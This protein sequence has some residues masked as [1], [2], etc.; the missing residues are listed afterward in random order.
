VVHRLEFIVPASLLVLAAIAA[1]QPQI[2]PGG[3][4]NSA[5]NAPVGWPNSSIA[6]GSIFAIYGSKLGPPSSPALQYPLLTTLVGVSVQIHSGG[7]MLNA[8]PI[9]AGPDQVPFCRS[10][11]RIVTVLRT[12]RTGSRRFP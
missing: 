5:S 1:A 11:H 2:A 6:Q 3:V 9:F 10:V 4:V 7:V 12:S 8:V